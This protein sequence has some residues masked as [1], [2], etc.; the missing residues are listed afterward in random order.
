MY[1]SETWS[2]KLR[3]Q[4]RLRVFKNRVLKRII[5]PKRDAV[6]GGW[7]KLHNDELHNLQSSPDTIRMKKSRR[8]RLAGHVA[9]MERTGM[10]IE[11]WWEGQ[12]ERD[13]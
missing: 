10:H 11:Y 1:G 9:R 4:H 8:M 5:A 12:K 6:I 7:R 2:L 3:E 13:H